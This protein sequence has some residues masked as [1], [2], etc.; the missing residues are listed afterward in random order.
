M[1]KLE[2]KSVFSMIEAAQTAVPYLDLASRPATNDCMGS[3]DSYS[4]VGW[5]NFKTYVWVY[6]TPDTVA[7]MTTREWSAPWHQLGIADVHEAQRL[8]STEKNR[9]K[10]FGPKVDLDFGGKIFRP[11]GN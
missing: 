7:G 1:F 9:I 2:A 11:I 3:L 4:Y 8:I 10:L 6:V 5:F